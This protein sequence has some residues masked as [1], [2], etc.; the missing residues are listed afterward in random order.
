MRQAVLERRGL[1]LV[2]V[3]AL[4]ILVHSKG[5]RAPLLDYH[6]HREVNTASIARN[7]WRESRPFHKPR[8]D[9]N[10]PSDRMAATELP[11]YM[12]LYGKLWP[13]GGLGEGWGRLI[14]AAASLL[15]ALLLFALVQ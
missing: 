11:V 2:F 7:Y 13:V 8:I 12:W 4:S 3:A 1:C 6:F 5:L 14:S 10:G 9:W 15:T